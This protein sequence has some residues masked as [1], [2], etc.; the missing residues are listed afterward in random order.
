MSKP[1]KE[2]SVADARAWDV[3]LEALDAD[4]QAAASIPTGTAIVAAD[5]PDRDELIRRY[6]NDDR[7]VAV[8]DAD[9]GYEVLPPRLRHRGSD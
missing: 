1:T 2:T 6:H 9:G 8:V 5:D 3:F 7:A 4:S